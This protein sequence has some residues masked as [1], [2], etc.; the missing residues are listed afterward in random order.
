EELHGIADTELLREGT[1]RRLERPAAGDVQPQTRQLAPRLRQRA[2]QHDVALD[3]DQASDAQKPKLG[4]GVRPHA[5]V[6]LDP[7]VND[8]E[9]LAV[10]TLHVLEIAREAARDRDVRVRETRNPPGAE[11]EPRILRESVA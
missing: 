4:P 10:E 11:R 6:R 8:L 2:Q 7:V 1:Q 9:A 3:R 5:P